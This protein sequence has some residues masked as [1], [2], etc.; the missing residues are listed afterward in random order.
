MAIKNC[1]VGVLGVVLMLG[2]VEAAILY[3]EDFSSDPGWTTDDAAK[4][5]RDAGTNT[6]HGIQVNGEHTSAYEKIVGFDPNQSWRLE[7]DHKMNS[8]GW[9]AGLTFGLFDSS[10]WLGPGAAFDQGVSDGG[11]Y[12]TFTGNFNQTGIYSPAWAAG[13]WYRSIMEYDAVADQLTLN[14]TDRSS[15]SSLW[16]LSLNVASFG[17]DMT[18]LGVSRRHAGA[19]TSSSATADYNLDNIRL[20]GGNV[21]PEPSSLIVWSLIGLSLAG[22]RGWRRRRAV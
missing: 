21:V 1:I 6:F 17:S 10:L 3:E 18:Y 20:S 11:R 19:G 7:F 12:T 13:V 16:S 8:A 5:G 14:V 2:Q 22:I 4:L 9:S 15:G